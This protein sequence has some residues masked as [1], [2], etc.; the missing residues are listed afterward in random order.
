MTSS[1]YTDPPHATAEERQTILNSRHALIWFDDCPSEIFHDSGLC[2]KDA[3]A[4][5][6]RDI[7][8]SGHQSNVSTVFIIKDYN[9]GT[10]ERTIEFDSC[11]SM[12]EMSQVPCTWVLGRY[13]STYWVMR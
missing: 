7:V 11:E 5:W 2:V 8:E 1:S 3:L 6:A 12:A 13:G 9:N 10:L 4:A